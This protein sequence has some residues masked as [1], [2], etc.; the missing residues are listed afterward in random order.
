MS[1]YTVAL[2]GLQN[3]SLAIDTVSNNIANANT[4]GYKA[5]EYVFADQFVKAINPA[6]QARVGMG[7]QSLGVRRPMLQGTIT[8]SANPLDL[9][10][11]GKGMFRLLQGSGTAGSVDP[12]AVYY[13]RNGQ[14]GVDKEGFIVNENGMYLTGYQPSLDGTEISDDLIKNNGLLR[15]PNSNLP[16]NETT[17]SRLSAMLDSTSNAFTTTANV[18]FDPSQSTFNNKTTQTVFDNEGNSRTL[19]VYYRRVNDRSLTITIEA[20][21]SGYTYSPGPSSSPNTLGDTKVTMN[22]NSVL[23]VDT[24]PLATAQMSSLTGTALTLSSSPSAGGQAVDVTGK[25]VFVNGVD[26]GQTVSSGSGTALTLSG[27]INAS[28]GAAISFYEPGATLNMT[29]ITPDGTEVTVQGQTNRPGSGATLTTTMAEV[30]VYA[31]IDGRFYRTDPQSDS[32]RNTTAMNPQTNNSGTIQYKPVSKLQFIGGRNIDSLVT[33]PVSGNPLFKTTSTLT[34]RVTNQAGGTSDLVFELDL[35]DTSLQAGAFQITHS[36]QNGEPLARLTNV[37]VDNQGRIVGVYGTGKQQF[38]GQVALVH[39]DNAEGL[40]P[41]G[42]NAFAAS[43]DSGTEHSADG[44]LV[45][46]AG[47]GIFGDIKGQ[48]LESSNVDLANELV[49]LM[50]LQRSYSANSQSMKAFD[51]TLRDTLQMVS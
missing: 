33:D 35:S 32:N 11:S 49:R 39:F 38:V 27:S 31:S 37:T 21:G 22:Q 41:V 6:D 47:T 12:S 48:A 4:V 2:S 3:T 24:A 28:A 46:R 51:Q 18:A 34:T 14:F 5:G 7:T 20:N 36:N 23:R 30:E 40:I 19:E 13:S 15:M 17:Y 50:V 25:R 10:I 8:N 9:A 43:V 44:V 42:K 1:N 26:S 16:G 29:L 45:G